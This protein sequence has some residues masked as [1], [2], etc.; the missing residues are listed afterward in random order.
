MLI[1]HELSRASGRDRRH[2]IG[3]DLTTDDDPDVGHAGDLVQAGDSVGQAIRLAREARGM[4]LD[5]LSLATRIKPQFLAALEAMRLEELPSRPFVVGYVRACAGAL[6]LDPEAAVERFRREAP[7]GP[8]TLAAPVGVEHS[9]DPWVRMLVALGA[10]VLLAIVTWN[11]FERVKAH[12]P[13]VRSAAASTAPAVRPPISSRAPA[14]PVTLGAPL[15]PPVEATAPQPYVTPGLAA[16]SNAPLSAAP[17]LPA[18]TP[19]K[20]RGTVYGAAAATA[21]IILVARKPVSFVIHGPNGAVYFARQLE[22]GEAYAAP[23]LDG[24]TADVSDPTQVDVYVDRALKGPLPAPTTSLSSLTA[25][26]TAAAHPAGAAPRPAPTHAAT[27][28]PA[29]PPTEPPAE[30]PGPPT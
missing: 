14:G 15:P 4:S 11:I 27:A 12:G 24:L 10:V 26:G 25:A 3:L 1:N 28:H 23:A 18:G 9:A 2:P 6:G 20:T 21:H 5:Q 22:T 29:P 8:A 13:S 30:A 16:S 7:E 19:F 17:A